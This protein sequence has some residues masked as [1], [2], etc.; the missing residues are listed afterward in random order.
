MSRND[1]DEGGKSYA[2]GNEVNYEATI[3]DYGFRI[4]RRSTLCILYTWEL[5]QSIYIGASW[6]SMMATGVTHI[7]AINFVYQTVGVFSTM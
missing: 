5:Q 3:T 2:H 7:F 4:S 6:K 1:E